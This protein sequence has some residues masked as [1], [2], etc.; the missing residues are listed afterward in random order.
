MVLSQPKNISVECQGGTFR[1]RTA[2]FGSGQT[3]VGSSSTTI[4]LASRLASR[5][6]GRPRESVDQTYFSQ[7]NPLNFVCEK[8]LQFGFRLAN[9]QGAICTSGRALIPDACQRVG[10]GARL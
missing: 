6:F 7:D 9:L 2:E 3:Q 8:A 1:W 10:G 4:L 5:R